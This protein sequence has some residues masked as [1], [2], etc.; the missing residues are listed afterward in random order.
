MILFLEGK[1]W[2]L[3]ERK[4]QQQQEDKSKKLPDTGKMM[5]W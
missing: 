3:N 5:H 1:K 4:W 2:L